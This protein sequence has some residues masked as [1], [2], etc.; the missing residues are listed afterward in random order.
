MNKGLCI[1]L[2]GLSGSGKTTIANLLKTQLYT[3]TRQHAIILDGDEIRQTINYDLGLSKNNRSINVRKIGN[4]AN[5]ITK[6][7]GIAICSNIAPY[8]NDRSYN[9]NLIESNGNIYIE[10][11]LK[12][13]IN[14]CIKRDPKGLYKINKNKIIESANE[15]EMP[16]NN[17]ITINTDVYTKIQS[18]NTILAFCNTIYNKKN[19]NK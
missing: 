5:I 12:S 7:N 8:Q 14:E 4:I 9:R 1:Y 19:E 16:I 17:E 18:V 13:S 2:T 15:Y 10:V 3:Y 11:F 6:N